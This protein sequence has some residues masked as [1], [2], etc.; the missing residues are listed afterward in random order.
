MVS[1][2]T[3]MDV[4]GEQLVTIPVVVQLAKE[5]LWAFQCG[6]TLKRSDRTP[7]GPCKINLN[8]WH[9]LQQVSGLCVH[10]VVFF[11]N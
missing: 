7:G 9:N 10:S 1:P 11:H 2:Q 8:S 4:D 6:W 3:R 5:K